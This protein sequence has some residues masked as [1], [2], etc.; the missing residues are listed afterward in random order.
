MSS[1]RSFASPQMAALSPRARRRSGGQALALA[2]TLFLAVL[3]V[4]AIVV[5][6]A[7][8]SVPEI[9]SLYTSTT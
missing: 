8:P 9:G 6:S 7:A 2:V 5:A 4:E 3:I 1:I